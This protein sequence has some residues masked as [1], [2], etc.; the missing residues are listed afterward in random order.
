M[1]ELSSFTNSFINDKINDYEELFDD[2][3]EEDS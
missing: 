3:D 1:K 2:E